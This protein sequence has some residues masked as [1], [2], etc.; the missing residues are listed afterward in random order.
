MSLD[1]VAPVWHGVLAA[2]QIRTR[3]GMADPPH[4][5]WAVAMAHRYSTDS[6][7][8]SLFLCSLGTPPP[9]AGMVYIPLVV[10]RH[11]L[12]A[13]AARRMGILRVVRWVVAPVT[14]TLVISTGNSAVCMMGAVG[15]GGCAAPNVIREIEVA[16]A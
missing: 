16:R 8:G 12:H 3:Q 14:C 15:A 4:G 2:F 1:P 7:T 10:G 11:A 13:G 9:P 6:G 5:N